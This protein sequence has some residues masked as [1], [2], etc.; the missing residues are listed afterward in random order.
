MV[1]CYLMV[2][3]TICQCPLLTTSVDALN[4]NVALC[5]LAYHF[6]PSNIKMVLLSKEIREGFMFIRM[7]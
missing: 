1:H 4:C 6:N 2:D 3:Q 5:T 7:C